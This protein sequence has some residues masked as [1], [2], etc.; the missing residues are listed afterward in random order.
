MASKQRPS[1][2]YASDEIHDF[3]CSV[4]KDDNLNIEAKHFCGDCSKYYCDKCLT[5]HAKIH[6]HHVVLGCK[7]VD[8]WVGQGDALVTC[9]LHPPK[10]I[11]LLCEDHN[12]LCCHL[13][14]PLN[15]RMC[16]SISLISDLVKGIYKM[17]DFK[18][19]PA[20]VTKVTDRLNQVKEARKKNQ[21]SLNTSGK[22]MLTKIKTLRSSLNELLD[23]LEK[24]TVEQVYSVLADLNGSLQKDIDHCDLLHDQLKALLD[25]VQAQGKESSSYIGFKK[26]EDKMEEANRLLHE[27]ENK[28]EA[29]I[30]FQPDTHAQQLLSDLK[31][32]ANIHNDPQFKQSSAQ[33]NQSSN[34]SKVFKVEEKKT[35]AVNIKKDKQDCNITGMTELPGGEIVLVDFQNS[36]VKVLDSKYKVTS[37]CDLPESPY[38]ICHISDHQV[39]VAVENGTDRHEVHFLTVSADTI[40]MT[41]KFSVDHECG[42][43]K[44]H[45]GQLYV[46]SL[47]P[48]IYTKQ[49]EAWSTKYMKTHLGNAQ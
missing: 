34:K 48:C 16:G 12:E 43:I 29:T 39:A 45:G 31:A 27:I 5:F 22:S 36:R 42:S 15:H 1:V 10:V 7:D 30:T 18:Q 9:N 3:S 37:N 35:Y 21:N 46:G 33:I 14:V 25:T 47:T 13:C 11:E 17:T 26:C 19:L 6:K 38:D 8:K 24:R 4:C 40:K 28:Q 20:K 49:M 41:R 2:L 23:D 32:L 44:H